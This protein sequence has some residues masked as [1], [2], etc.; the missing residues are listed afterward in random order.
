MRK[1]YDF[2]NA[3]R[4]RFYRN[5]RPYQVTINVSEPDERSQ[6]EIFVAPDGKYRFRLSFDS[7]ILFTSETEYDTKDDCLK[8]VSVLRH[9]SVLAPTVYA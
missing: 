5:N 3:T 1:E 7:T 6:Y 8:A 4:G 9:A 2:S